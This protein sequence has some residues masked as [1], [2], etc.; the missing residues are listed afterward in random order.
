MFDS[1]KLV[2]TRKFILW[3]N[4][5][6]ILL[7]LIPML[8]LFRY[9]E[10]L[11]FQQV[12]KQAETV[13]QQ[14]LLTRKWIANHG[15]IYVEKLPWVEENPFLKKI[16]EKTKIMSKEGIVLIK[17]NPALVTRQLS[18]LAKENNL[19]W[20]KLTSLK[21][22]NPYNQPDLTEIKALKLFQNKLSNEYVTIEKVGDQY[23]YRLI[24]PLVTEK[25]C[26][27]CH[28]KQGYKEGDIRGA[29]SIFIP[30]DETLIKLSYYKKIT[31]IIF[32]L[33][34]IVLNF[35]I[36]FLSN[37]FIFRPFYCTIS[38]LK[39][40]RNLY[41]KK[42]KEEKT[43]SMKINSEWELLF[44]SINKFIS[45]IN[46][47]QERMEEK[48]KEV[49]KDL[50]EKNKVLQNLLEKRKFLITN[51]AHELKTPLTSVKGSI[52]YL[53]RIFES[54]L[55]VKENTNYTKIKEFLEISQKNINRL[56]QLFNALVDL[57]KA[58]A[59]LLELEISSFNLKELVEE[60][61]SQ[62][63]GLYIEKN[64]KF[65]IN[66]RED[67]MIHA[68]REKL[69]IVLSNLL[70]NAIKYSPYGGTITIS[71]YK[72][73][74]KIRLE[75]EDEGKGLNKEDLERIFDRFYKKDSQGFGLGLA[76]SKA[77]VEAH[78]GVLGAEPREK[79]AL[80]YFEI[81]QNISILKNNGK[82][83]SNSR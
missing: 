56:I 63:Q 12:K 40:L 68:D 54:E 23:N 72:R 18:Q 60:V 7:L 21:Y 10:G 53:K 11:I 62:L 70:T 30:L 79:G 32:F 66:I 48:I 50:E 41:G 15:G 3:L 8:I 83:N 59:N 31:L 78:G 24:K 6:L 71:F 28:E 55:S 36:L 27:K 58:E 19:Y 43:L 49:T 73:E 44:D 42:F 61:I 2:V 22:L 26:L 16:G 20:F 35:A 64:L 77:Y 33:F 9:M 82:E 65:H 52:E 5:L 29:I 80:F 57:E 46:Y 37:R 1:L 4:L 76:I 25:S 17:Q 45:E 74:E 75:I 51:M 39:I 34:F 14:I 47:Y 67:S 81:P 69:S 38:L 13:Y